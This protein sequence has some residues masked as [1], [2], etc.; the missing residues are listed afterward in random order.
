MWV[1]V[2]RAV[3]SL[4]MS[5]VRCLVDID[6]SSLSSGQSGRAAFAGFK[7]LLLLAYIYMCIYIYI[8]IYIHGF[9]PYVGNP[10]TGVDPHRGVDPHMGLAHM[11]G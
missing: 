10:Q 7:A 6:D 8:Y 9:D 11:W 2:C 3:V 1:E 5:P 4:L